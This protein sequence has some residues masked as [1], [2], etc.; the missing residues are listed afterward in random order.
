MKFLNAATLMTLLRYLL[1]AV[2]GVLVANGKF[3]PGAWDTI[4]GAVLVLLPALFGVLASNADKAVINGK[5]VAVKNLPQ[6]TQD[7]VKASVKAA[8]KAAIFEQLFGV[9]FKKT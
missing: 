6:T 5:T 1:Q 7:A 9:F 3:D 2:G 4:S 8:P